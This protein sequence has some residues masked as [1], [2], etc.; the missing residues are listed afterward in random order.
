MSKKFQH[1]TSPGRIGTL[2]TRNRMVVSAMG[3]NLANEDGTCGDRIIAF[4]ER[5]A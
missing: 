1:L 3:I 2:E 5:H 4:H